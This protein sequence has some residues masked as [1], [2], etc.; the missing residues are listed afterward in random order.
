MK[1]ESFRI[2]ETIA[3]AESGAGP[4][5]VVPTLRLEEKTRPLVSELTGL[6]QT[7]ETVVVWRPLYAYRLLRKLRNQFETLIPRYKDTIALCHNRMSQPVERGSS[8]ENAW[9]QGFSTA[10][11]TSVLLQLQSTFQSV[12][13][14]LDR[15]AAY[16]VAAFSLYI[17]VLSMILTTVF[18]W[19]SLK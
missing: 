13:E 6:A 8:M 16:S 1:S 10:V 19:L 5:I 18:G 11:G 12:G 14:V 3:E 9:L 15:K 4:A 17:A 7:G 2:V